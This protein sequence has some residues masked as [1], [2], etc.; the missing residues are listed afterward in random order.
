M[1]IYYLQSC[2][3]RIDLLQNSTIGGIIM[4]LTFECINCGKK[5][6]LTVREFN[7]LT[8]KDKCSFKCNC[9]KV[10]KIVQQ[11]AGEFYID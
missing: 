11:D 10:N 3:E 2:I 9:G 6:T 4:E 1:P 7:R 5:H 8:S